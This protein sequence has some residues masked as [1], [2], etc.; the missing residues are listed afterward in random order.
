MMRVF[1]GDDRVKIGVEVGR[2]LGEGYEVVDGEMVGVADMDSLFYGVSLFGEVRRILVK[3]LG[4]DAA[5]WERLPRY[6]DTEH[7]VV[8]WEGRVDRRT[9]A[10]RELVKG[11]VEVREFGVAGPVKV[12]FDILGVALAGDGARAVRMVEGVEVRSDPYMFVGLMVSQAVRRLE[13]GERRMVGVLRMLAEVDVGM[14]TSSLEPWVLV[15]V[16]LVRV[17]FL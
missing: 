3:D 15:K 13:G 16:F 1:Y 8:V 7:E 12:E 5:V 11:G 14:K 4:G 17:S 9:S 10:Y 6:L 2:I